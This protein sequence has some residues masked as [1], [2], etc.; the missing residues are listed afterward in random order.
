MKM[1]Q[2]STT[3]MRHVGT[4][5]RPQKQKGLTLVELMVGL[6]I[7]L[8]IIAIA[9]VAFNATRSSQRTTGMQSQLLQV[10][11]AVQKVAP[12]PNYNGVTEATVIQAG[13]APTNMVN[14]TSLVNSFGGSVT[15][16]AATYGGGTGAA[17]N[18][19]V[20]TFNGVP[21]SECNAVLASAN[22]TFTRIVVGTTAVKDQYGASPLQYNTA[23]ATAACDND[24]NSIS[25]TYSS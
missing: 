17:D 19:F 12:G 25:F 24:A 10:V 9:I 21:R 6:L 8:A 2:I 16:A 14:G 18:A 23:A 4:F 11:A 5:N 3:R 15:I 13:H 20:T 22:P 1:E 7:A